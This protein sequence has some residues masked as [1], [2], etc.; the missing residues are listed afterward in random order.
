MLYFCIPTHD[1]A[2]TVGLLCWKIRRVLE[3]TSREYQLL[4]GDDASTDSTGEVLAAYAKALPIT[5][6]RSERRL[7]Y[8]ATVERLL[9]EALRRSDR[10]KRDAVILMPADFTFDP[11]E[12]PEF[13]KRIDSGA[14]LVV[15]EA[16][17]IGEDD[18][19]RRRV[20]Q[21][22]HHLLGRRA[23]VPGIRDVVSGVLAF[24]LVTLRAAFRDRPDRWLTTEDWAANAEL[25]SW[26]AAGAR[27]IESVPIT[28]RVERRQRESR[29]DAW[30]RAKALWAARR[31]L[32]APPSNPEA[33]RKD[34]SPRAATTREAA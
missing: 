27:Q 11:A 18:K 26:A 13:L 34:R 7:G 33:P 2:P 23:R 25:L 16:T 21:W 12:L 9:K 20:R 14:D 31:Q 8:A 32:E 4:V 6:L 28:E 19:W 22:A 5:V 10:H 15:G 24:R 17:L 29:H 1:E 30:I 3:E